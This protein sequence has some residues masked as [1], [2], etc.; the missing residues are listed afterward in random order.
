MQLQL[1]KVGNV[2][3]TVGTGNVRITQGQLKDRLKVTD[4]DFTPVVNKSSLTEDEKTAVKSAIYA[5]NDKTV[6][7]IKDIEVANDG[8]ATIVY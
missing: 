7:R 5:K 3:G 6:H 4:P 1:T 2:N 8:T